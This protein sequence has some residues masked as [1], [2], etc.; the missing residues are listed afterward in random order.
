VNNVMQN[1]DEHPLRH[2]VPIH[3]IEQVLLKRALRRQLEGHTLET[4]IEIAELVEKF[5]SDEIKVPREAIDLV[6]AL[7]VRLTGPWPRLRLLESLA[8]S[9]FEARRAHGKSSA[10]LD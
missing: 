7:C 1:I 10:A 5:A 2:R 8:R 9:R 4:S 6:R 3:A